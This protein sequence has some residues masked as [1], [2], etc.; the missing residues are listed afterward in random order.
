MVIRETLVE[1]LSAPTWQ[2]LAARRFHPPAVPLCSGQRICDTRL[3]SRNSGKSGSAQRVGYRMSNLIQTILQSA[4]GEMA[5]LFRKTDWAPTAV[6]K[7]E[8]WPV[9]LQMAAGVALTSRFPM[10]LWWGTELS[11]LYNDAWRPVLGATKHPQF[12]GQSGKHAWPEIWDVIGPMLNGVLVTGKATWVTDQLL[13]VHRYGYFEEAYFTYSYS[14][15]FLEDGTV[16]GVFSAVH[17][18]TE[19]VISER[20]LALL[21]DLGAAVSDI[22]PVETTLSKIDEILKFDPQDV[23]FATLYLAEA[24]HA[25]MIR[26]TQELTAELAPDDL[27]LDEK[28]NGSLGQVFD[29]ERFGIVGPAWPDT[30]RSAIWLPL[31]AAGQQKASGFVL[32]GI[33]PR[34]SFDNSYRSFVSLLAGQIAAAINS[35]KAYELEL[36]R[37]RVLAELDRA[38]TVFFNDVSHEFRTP[39]TLML[40]PL[41]HLGHQVPPEH[42]EELRIVQRNASRLLKL[43][44]TLLDFSRIEAGRYEARFVPTDIGLLTA[45]IA[46]LFRSA[47]ENAGLTLSLEC[48]EL[49]EQPYVDREMWEKII[50]NLMSNAFKFTVDGGISVSVYQ[51][52]NDVFVS[53]KDTGIGVPASEIGNLFKRFHRLKP[54]VSRTYEGTGIGLAM[55][56]ELVHLHGGKITV[57]SELNKGTEFVV[58][59]PLGYKHLP[60]EQVQSNAMTFKPRIAHDFANE[61]TTWLKTAP[62]EALKSTQGMPRSTE[63]ILVVD[64]NADMRSYLIRL[65]KQFW[66][67]ECVTNGREAL[68]KLNAGPVDL[69]ISDVMMPEMNGFELVQAIRSSERLNQTPVLLLSA[70]AGEEAR[71]GGLEAGAD[72]YLIKPFSPRELYARVTHLLQQ[73]FVSRELE[74]AVS[75][76]TR[77]LEDALQARARFLSTVSHEVRTPLAGVI[78]LIELLSVTASDEESRLLS[79]SALDASKR[80]LQILNDM[81]DASKLQTG[82]VTLEHRL[83]ALRPI[84]GDIV[85]LIKPEVGN[86]DVVVTSQ[87]AHDVPNIVCGDELRLRQV[88][89]NLALNAAKFTLSGK[90][91]ISASLVSHVAGV[92]RVLFSVQDTGSG[93]NEEQLHNIFE[94]FTKAQDSIG[95]T[96]AGS[97]LGL[98]ICR[99]LTELMSEQIGV[100]SRFGQGSTF[101]VEIPFNEDACKCTKSS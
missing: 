77:E 19:K 87:V 86:R 85:Q 89:L 22:D 38:K 15:I 54:E 76:R 52:D 98:T 3:A 72:D 73:R 33:N 96:F 12:L 41:E 83:F 62:S 13:V 58:Q 69:V 11:M 63:R 40:G 78:G 4:D 57:S 1:S 82:K 44:N 61:A 68:Q 17:E 35:S 88:L 67:V 5:E 46:S 47:I 26:G 21:R 66:S 8:L 9:P 6:G 39:L 59:V 16:G 27:F 18:T 30:V 99:T 14:P 100:E 65:L 23:P 51:R 36:E 28:F 79:T 43:V 50:S 45:D 31:S 91:H 49:T 20:R 70:R 95:A 29:I 84:I 80:L 24:E 101:W 97:G 92:T 56:N 93:I 25:K 71:A 55:V 42:A 32:L 64:D 10:V 48:E 94:P 74:S 2:R 37:T 75:R 90:I 81:L 53:V 60:A 34:R 7:M